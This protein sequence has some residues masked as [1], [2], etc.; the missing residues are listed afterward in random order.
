VGSWTKTG[1]AHSCFIMCY[2]YR[3]TTGAEECTLAFGQESKAME[4]PCGNYSPL[5]AAMSRSLFFSPLMLMQHEKERHKFPK[6][7][8]AV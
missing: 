6:W 7:W 5:L 3:L 4:P 2:T 8:D 1:S